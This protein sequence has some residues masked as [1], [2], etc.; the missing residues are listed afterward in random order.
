MAQ[1]KGDTLM[2]ALMYVEVLQRDIE[3]KEARLEQ[4]EK[5]YKLEKP[6]WYEAA[7][8]SDIIKVALFIGG[9]YLGREMV[10]VK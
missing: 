10:V 4:F 7:W 8:D 1:A 6:P 5:L 9:V 2:A 3:V